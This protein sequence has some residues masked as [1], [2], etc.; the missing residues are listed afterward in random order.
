MDPEAPLPADGLADPA[1]AG[2][3]ARALFEQSPLS[4]VVYD[5]DGRLVLVN[6]AFE[7]LWE[8][9]LADIPP[10]YCV[11]RDPQLGALGLLPQVR[12][13]FAGEPVVLPPLR[14]DAA[15][16]SGGARVTWTQAHLYP[17]R[18][19]AGEVSSVVLVHVDLTDRVEAEERTAFLAEAGRVL[20]ESLDVEETL[21]AVAGLAVPLLGDF[22]FV[23]VR[24]GTGLR[25]VAAA[26]APGHDAALLREAQRHPPQPGRS[27][28]PVWRVISTGRT[29]LLPEWGE[30]A[31]AAAASG[32]EHAR[33]MRALGGRSLL[34]VPLAWKGETFGALTFLMGA[35]GR[36]H[37][38]RDRDLAEEVGR[39]AASA[40]ANAR[41]HAQGEEVRAELEAR[42]DEMQDQAT[43]LEE[44]RVELEE[45][46]REAQ[47]LNAALEA[48]N[49]ELVAAREAAEAAERTTRGIL[50]GIAD[51]FVV[52]DAEWRFRYINEPAA[53]V[54]RAAGRE[55]RDRLIGRVLW[56]EYPDLVGSRFEWE[57]RRAVETGAPAAFEEFYPGSGTWS[58]LRCYPLPGGGLATVWKDVT[59]RRREEEAAHLL[60]SASAVLSAS[61]EPRE[62]LD[63]VSRLFVPR[64]ADWCTVYLRDADGK[65]ERVALA[66]VDP[67]REEEAWD[68]GRR[69][70]P[71]LESDQGMG[72]VLRSGEPLLISDVTEE[73]VAAAAKDDEHRRILLQ[74]GM[75]SVIMVPLA[76]RGRV[77][78]AMTLIAAAS[79]R[80][81]GDEDVALAGE[82]AHRA[83]VAVD[84]AR[85]F[86]ETRAARE[87]AEA[88]N[89]AK[90]EFLAVMSHELRTPL[91]A[92]GG[93]AQLLQM[94][95]HGP[96][97]PPQEE[98]LERIQ[99]AQRHLLSLINDVLNYARIEA[100]TVQYLRER[101]PV[102]EMLEGLDALV[103]PQLAARSLRYTCEAVDDGMAA[104][105]DGEKVRQVL[106][107]LLSNAVKF[108]PEGG[109]VRVSAD[110]EGERVRVHVADTGPGIP[111]DKREAVF[112]PFV[113]LGRGLSS[114]QEGTGLGLAISRDLAR[115][116]GGDLTVRCGD[117]G[118]STFTLVLPRA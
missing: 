61:L 5:P 78:G 71:D 33:V 118:G 31:M 3:L 59:A 82:L 43:L 85:L 95:V 84:N 116:M 93:Y 32:P 28:N 51:P 6:G 10:D 18:G 16:L 81:Y 60:A 54:F 64:L 56:E 39:R 48:A 111:A 26:Q 50:E 77:L 40:I 8:L 46:V 52:H 9:R 1:L 117:E 80:R 75:R 36:V 25:R 100:A 112:E 110:A 106:L 12:R 101:V 88:A 98:A 15:R 86:A 114:V 35:S 37:D 49:R 11:L 38:E 55:G 96:V 4:T 2:G 87:E 67:T 73:M 97:A 79:G 90:S 102:A 44:R 24:Q 115:G 22:C 83:A 20:H 105:A 91:N 94:G 57:M 17:V 7:R 23:D 104:M 14:Y 21:R 27:A 41:L 53:A 107:N 76:A 19:A 29:E 30:E 42:A 108:T 70:P 66:H 72:R 89:R 63:A 62:T 103:A 13:A 69:Y 47:E 74:V 34:S 109:E 113:Q 68:L 65:V 58:E 45:R 99:R 92:I